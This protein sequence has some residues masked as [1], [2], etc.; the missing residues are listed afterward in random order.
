MMEYF[1]SSANSNSKFVDVR[2]EVTC[3]KNELVQFQLPAWRPGRYEIGN[4]G[5][6]LRG[7]KATSEDKEL[8]VNK[9]T[10]DLWEVNSGEVENIIVTYQYYA[11][12]LNAGS[13][14]VSEDL[15]YVNPVNCLLYQPT[16]IDENCFLSIKI[17]STHQIVISLDQV[18]DSESTE[19]YKYTA[20]SFHE[21]ADSPFIVSNKLQVKTYQ[22]EKTNFHV[23][24]AGECK[25]DWEKVLSDFKAFTI[26]M[27][28]AM[29]SFPFNQFYFLIHALPYSG[30]HGVE[31]QK[32]TVITLGP[33]YQMFSG[34]GY[35]NLLG[36]SSHELYHTWNVKYIRPADLLPYD[37][38]KENYS[39]LGYL[40]EGVTTYLGD[41]FLA[42][43]EVVNTTQF[44]E[45]MNANLNKHFVNY[46]RDY[47]S[48]ADS[49]VD[50][51]LDGYVRGIPNR[52]T[53]IYTEGALLSMCLDALII[54]ESNGAKSIHD[55]MQKLYL[56]YAN[57]NK[58]ISED[59]FLLEANYFTNNKF[60]E[61]LW[62]H[63]HKAS[64]LYLVVKS[65]LEKIG[66][67]TLTTENESYLAN[68]LGLML[69]PQTNKVLFIATG[70][71]AEEWGFT[72]GDEIV[73]VNNIK[74][75]GDATEWI[76]YF[77]GTVNLVVLK[78]N[79]Y[80]TVILNPSNNTFFPKVTL[81]L[82]TDADK[83]LLRLQNIW[84]KS[85][86]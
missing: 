55:F 43:S 63:Y 52:K 61:I 36:I 49:S 27:Y 79:R 81:I 76:N 54:S 30:Y 45:L 48:V 33:G 75:N 67:N 77:G 64:D 7:L 6:N 38:S 9:K 12:E 83:D 53:S 18:G 69:E 74:T 22:V 85:N 34:K 24:F 28:Q 23:C 47:L 84:L 16:K 70:S 42:Q 40:C 2:I 80:K 46:G 65:S 5:K 50:T 59:I 32:N 39:K 35:D 8:L 15:L 68:K 51:W 10:K 60:A 56:D 62:S 21:L 1:I 25:P 71:P 44:L 57:E 11:S 72:I 29:G 20:S 37:Y 4:F 14:Y 13:T 19:S 66:V 82:N 58:G 26:K 31:H 3:E 86:L 41:L 17:P 78:D 73:E